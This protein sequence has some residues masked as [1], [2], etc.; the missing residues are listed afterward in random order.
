MYLPKL[1]ILKVG[2]RVGSR[3][4][5]QS[6]YLECETIQS[7]IPNVLDLQ[8]KKKKANMLIFQQNIVIWTSTYPCIEMIMTVQSLGKFTSDRLN[9]LPK[10]HSKSRHVCHI[11]CN[12]I[13]VK[14]LGT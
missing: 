8:L 3:S 13:L 7:L 14:S 2:E 11:Q 9:A 1:P 10:L 6:A 12:Q 4:Q 5:Q